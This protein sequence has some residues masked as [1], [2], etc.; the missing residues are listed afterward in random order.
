MDLEKLVYRIIDGYYTIESNGIRYKIVLPNLKIKNQ[1]HLL[2]L[3]TLEDSKFD[4]DCWLTQKQIDHLLMIYGLWNKDSEKLLEKTKK[5][6]DNS[7]IELYKHYSNTDLRPKLKMMIDGLKNQIASLYSRKTS[8]DYLTLEFYAQTIK[9]QF[10]LAN[11][12]FYEETDVIA[13]DTSNLGNFGAKLIEEIFFEIHSNS[14]SA[15]IIRDVAKCDIWQSL[16]K[17]SHDKIFG[18][19]PHKWTDEQISLVN[20]SKVLDSIREH[21]ESPG[22]EI[23]MDDDALDGWI[24][25]QNQKNEKEK[26]QNEVLDKYN[27][28]NKNAGEIFVVSNNADERRS[29]YG[30]NDT[31]TNRDI[32][33]AAKISK[34]KGSVEWSEL[35]HVQKQLKQQAM[36][37]RKK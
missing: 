12:V 22:E 13:F 2:Y 14:I 19:N 7:K 3:N 28:R 32:M 33:Q 1:A 35:P 23:I 20:Y 8:F 30:L 21:M 11:M 24:L 18:D 27:L 15:D 34:E 29:I 31:Q 25:F 37:Q 16:W 4:V 17:I 6:L 26:K 9:S 36:E 5:D 10:L